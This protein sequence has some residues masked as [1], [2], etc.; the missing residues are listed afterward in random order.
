MPPKRTGAEAFEPGPSPK[1]SPAPP[2]WDPKRI[3]QRHYPPG[4]PIAQGG[5]GE[6]DKS[7]SFVCYLISPLR[8]S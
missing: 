3:P 1:D 7:H 8:P 2:P 4:G 6:Y 5:S